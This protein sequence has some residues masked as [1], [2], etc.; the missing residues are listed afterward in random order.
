MKD[1]MRKALVTGAAGFI[2]RHLSAALTERGVGVHKLDKTQTDATCL[3]CD[4]LNPDDLREHLRWFRPDTVFHLAAQTEVGKSFEDPCQTY[5]TNVVGTLNVLEACRKCGVE[6][7]V[8]ASSDKAYGVSGY[9]TEDTPLQ[10]G[11]DPYS[12]SKRLADE[13]AQVYEQVHSLPVKILRPCNTYGPGQLNQTTLITGTVA[14]VLRGDV[15]PSSRCFDIGDF[16]LRID[17]ANVDVARG[18]DRLKGKLEPLS[19]A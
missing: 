13:L 4:V 10:V 2:G 12:N 3:H 17:V 6:S 14:R 16:S 9:Y 8:V 11:P 7:V 15:D 18:S 5:Q 19:E 1:P